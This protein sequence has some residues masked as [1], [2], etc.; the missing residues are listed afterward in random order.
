MTKA[1]NFNFDAKVSKLLKLMIH[2]IYTNK[3]IFLRELISNAIDAIEKRKYLSLQNQEL[4]EN[5][6]D[7][8]VKLTLN[9]EKHI[10]I[11][12]DNGIGMN[13]EE[14]ISNLG[15]IAQSGT[16]D[17]VKNLTQSANQTEMIGQ[18][19]VGFY[20]VFMVAKKVEV[21]SR[22][23]GETKVYKWS[24]EGEEGYS[25][26]EID[27][28][29]DIGTEITIHLDNEHKEKYSD[30]WHIEHIVKTY[31]GSAGVS[32]EFNNGDEGADF[33]KINVST[34]LWHQDKKN[35]TSEEYK[36]FYKSLSHLPDDPLITIHYRA[37][38]K[39]EYSSLLFIPSM[40]PF[41]LFHPDRQTRIKL[42]V[43]KVF[44][45]E[46]GL[47]IIPKY[48]RFVYGVIDSSDLPLNISRETLQNTTVLHKISQSITDK[49]IKEL[50]IYSEKNSENY[51]KLWKNFGSVIKEGLCEQTSPRENLLQI[52]RFY[53]SK[54]PDKVISLDE[55]ISRMIPEQKDI[56][57]CTGEEVDEIMQNPQIEAFLSSG[58][59]VL[60]L[61]DTVDGFWINVVTDYLGKD[62]KSITRADINIDGLAKNIDKEGKKEINLEEEDELN[63]KLKKY[64]KQALED[65]VKEIRVSHK[66]TDS[67]ASIAIDVGS[68]DIK[69]E[70]FL[71]EQN[72]I[73]KSSLKILEL[74]PKNPLILSVLEQ[75][76][77]EETLLVAKEMALTIFEIACIAQGE[78]IK[79]PALFAK[80]VAKLLIK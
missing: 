3:D 18:F 47:D 9:P 1:E 67:P 74:N 41:D 55:Y 52:C 66:M 16:E 71:M 17:F 12:R 36:E 75:L 30:K 45:C 53:S 32:I 21:K 23:A 10:L 78:P 39:T 33:V 7:Y 77:N 58:I 49:I 6:G 65:H 22:K 48:L 35:V 37:E 70:R 24:S 62:F 79:H 13:Y 72:Q 25:I 4:A 73:S 51:E 11:L 50:K 42:Y 59:E 26:K 28:D 29:F 57:Y 76:Q 46:Q 15:T 27:A 80:R 19:G 5:G 14:L 8:K 44:I 34:P 63:E 31:S 68:M 54:S 56:F 69:M 43:K 60:A 2:S 40:K 61:T 20:S 38:G 64:F